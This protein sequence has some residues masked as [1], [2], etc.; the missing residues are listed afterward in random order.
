MEPTII[1]EMEYDNDHDIVAGDIT[2]VKVVHHSLDGTKYER[3]MNVV[4]TSS[5]YDLVNQVVEDWVYIKHNKPYE[6]ES[7]YLSSRSLEQPVIYHSLDGYNHPYND[8]I[9]EIK[10]KELIVVTP[11]EKKS[12]AENPLEKERFIAIH[13]D[14]NGREVSLD[15]A[16]SSMPLVEKQFITNSFEKF[17]REY[18]HYNSKVFLNHVEHRKPEMVEDISLIMD[19]NVIEIQTPSMVYE[20]DKATYPIGGSVERVMNYS[21]HSEPVR[22]QVMSVKHVFESQPEIR[23]DVIVSMEKPMEHVIRQVP[24]SRFTYVSPPSTNTLRYVDRQRNGI[25]FEPAIN[26]Q[27]NDIPMVYGRT[28]PKSQTLTPRKCH[29]VNYD[30]I[31]NN[32]GRRYI[33]RGALYPPVCCTPPP[34]CSQFPLQA[35]SPRPYIPEMDA[36]IPSFSNQ[37][38]RNTLPFARR[39]MG[40]LYPK[41]H[42][43]VFPTT[44]FY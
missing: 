26:E 22:P 30:T 40:M 6:L 39:N 31:Y 4:N 35:R 36:E 20:Y 1:H 12:I 5:C 8:V 15:E 25:L 43:G 42:H 2:N 44:P 41:I 29:Q 21:L 13:T 23:K 10:E 28:I 3:E 14:L 24:D 16:W 7:T 37:I 34:C 18:E 11:T 32:N 33:Q 17:D 19:K 38:P 9:K 27:T